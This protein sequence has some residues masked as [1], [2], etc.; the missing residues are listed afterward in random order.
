MLPSFHVLLDRFAV[1]KYDRRPGIHRLVDDIRCCRAIHHINTDRIVFQRKETIYLAV[2]RI[3]VSLRIHDFQINLDARL[4]LI[5]LR[6]FLQTGTDIVD[7]GIV[8][9]VQRHADT[10]AL[11]FCRFCRAASI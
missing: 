8:A 11:F 3:L 9:P 1:E 5:F 4:L 7:K 2:L 10:D 6:L